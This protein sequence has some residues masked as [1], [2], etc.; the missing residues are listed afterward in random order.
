MF[1]TR[2]FIKYTWIGNDVEGVW[3]FWVKKT[4]ILV[5]EDE[6]FKKVKHVSDSDNKKK[7]FTKQLNK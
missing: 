4:F 5:F 7:I 6:G 1:F 3:G 2:Q